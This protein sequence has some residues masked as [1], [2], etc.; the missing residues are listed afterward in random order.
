MLPTP[1]KGRN[2]L[3]GLRE[4]VKE[5]PVVGELLHNLYLAAFYGEG[6]D[7]TIRAG[8]LKGMKFRRFM[9][10]FSQ[11]HVDGDFESELQEVFVA[12][13]KPGH[14]VYDVGSNV[15]YITLM[16][17]KLV[18][19]SG[20]VIAFEPGRTT[21]KQLRVQLAINNIKNVVVK[22]CAVSDK[23][24]MSEF[25]NGDC[26]VTAHLLD[27]GFAGNPKNL[28]T[29]SVQVISL[30]HVIT[31]HAVP[32]LVKIDVEGA[33]L[34]VLKGAE[35]LLKEHRPILV[36]ELHSENLSRGF[37]QLMSD[38]HY[39]VTLPSGGKAEPMNFSRHVVAKPCLTDR[40]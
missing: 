10:T 4:R 6:R 40:T 29:C 11:K 2:L 26:S 9:H 39:E 24:G 15:G 19:P 3:K 13:V 35:R 17:S 25:V 30:D 21:A 33:E 28:A 7:E 37:H 5:V 14:V 1:L 38:V 34:L 23:E 32:Q 8:V 36:V 31:Q 20:T 12:L 22:E 16:A 18:G 27:S